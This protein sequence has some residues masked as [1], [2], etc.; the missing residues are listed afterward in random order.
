MW[1]EV[2]CHLGGP[3]DLL[4][5]LPLRSACRALSL[6]PSPAAP[7]SLRL[8]VSPSVPLIVRKGGAPAHPLAR[9]PLWEP[10]EGTELV[11]SW[12]RPLPRSP[13]ELQGAQG[14]RERNSWTPAAVLGPT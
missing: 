4:P 8:S 12:A 6:E 7:A 13:A 5:N 1:G 2:G 9:T 10:T 3:T 14:A 11:D